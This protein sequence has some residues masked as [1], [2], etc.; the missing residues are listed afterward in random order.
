MGGNKRAWLRRAGPSVNRPL[1]I[2]Q[3][4]ENL[5]N[6]SVHQSPIDY[7]RSR[8]KTRQII[9]ITRNPNLVVNTDADQ[10]FVAS[11]N[12]A[13]GP[14][15]TYRSGALEDTNPGGPAQG[16]REEF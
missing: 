14:K 13:R 11:F 9:I 6:V 5:D 3:P 15:I 16:V 4:D 8:R 1:I 12:G 7:F 10:V 2:D